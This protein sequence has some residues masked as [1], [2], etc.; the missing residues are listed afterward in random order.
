MTEVAPSVER[1]M[2][3]LR[4]ESAQGASQSRDAQAKRPARRCVYCDFFA[5]AFSML[6]CVIG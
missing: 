3:P 6:A 1:A 5:N 2:H 4:D